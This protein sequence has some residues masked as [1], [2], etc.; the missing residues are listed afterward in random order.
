MIVNLYS[1]EYQCAVDTRTNSVV[2]VRGYE[3]QAPYIMVSEKASKIIKDTIR[4]GGSVIIEG[5]F[6]S[7]YNIDDI[8]KGSFPIEND[9][10]GNV[11]IAIG[12]VHP[13]EIGIIISELIISDVI[14][15]TY[16]GKKDQLSY[17]S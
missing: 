4:N 2:D 7:C 10:E 1:D 5:N 12:K 9:I 11:L 3:A 16:V 14:K 6:V 13:T 8:D 17:V 15:T